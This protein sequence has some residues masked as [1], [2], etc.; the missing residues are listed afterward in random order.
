MIITID[1]AAGTG[2]STV[3][4][5]VAEALNIAYFDTGA[6]YRAFA[7]FILVNKIDP[8]DKDAVTKAIKQ[9]HFTFD[10]VG[11]HKTYYVNNQDVTNLL[12]TPHVTDVS[13]IISQYGEVREALH[14]VQ[15]HFAAHHDSVFEGR[16]LGT[17]IFPNARFK[18]FLKASDEVRAQRRFDEMMSK[19][20]QTSYSEVLSSIR[21]RD[22]RDQS[23]KVAPLKCATDAFVIDTSL[24]KVE[25]VVAIIL[26]H[27]RMFS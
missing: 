23:R 22:D 14:S 26:N 21:E 11:S 3:A 9:F 4:K 25:D 1:G 24:I 20:I 12:R 8:S 19:G 27:I 16:D 2:K 15:K 17:V 5:K 18:F 7:C 10:G 6:M 13:S